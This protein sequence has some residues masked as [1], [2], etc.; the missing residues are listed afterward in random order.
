MA[1]TPMKVPARNTAA[2]KTSRNVTTM[3]AAAI[4]I[5]DTTQK[6]IETNVDAS[7]LSFTCGRPPSAS[8]ARQATVARACQLRSGRR[9]LRP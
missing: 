3:I 2:L 5:T 6:A 4:V 8:S 9:F 7:K 1:E